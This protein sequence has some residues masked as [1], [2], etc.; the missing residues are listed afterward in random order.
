MLYNIIT[1]LCIIITMPCNIITVL[2]NMITI[3]CNIVGRRLWPTRL[4]LWVEI[5][6]MLSRKRKRVC[7]DWKSFG[8]KMPGK[9]VLYL[10]VSYFIAKLSVYS[11]ALDREIICIENSICRYHS[12]LRHYLY[13]ECAVHSKALTTIITLPLY[14]QAWVMITR[15]EYNYIWIQWSLFV[16]SQSHSLFPLSKLKGYPRLWN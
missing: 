15:S 2:C 14:T 12:S 8:R 4:R 10:S 11:N 1:V 3:S 13:W 7:Y 5:Y 6:W 9:M 16:R